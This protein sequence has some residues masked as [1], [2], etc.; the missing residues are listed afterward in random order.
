M[1][2]GYAN[3]YV[4]PT[5]TAAAATLF[6]EAAQWLSINI[7]YVI[8]QLQSG[9][10]GTQAVAAPER[11]DSQV[12]SR[13]VRSWG[14][15]LAANFFVHYVNGIYGNFSQPGRKPGRQPGQNL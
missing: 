13:S 12:V 8:D 3:I 9:K 2:D 10:C 5:A 11:Q 4:S 7:V 1:H 14:R 6:V 15:S